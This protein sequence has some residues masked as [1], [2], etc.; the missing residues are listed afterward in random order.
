MLAPVRAVAVIAVAVLGAGPAP[1]SPA[2]A[3]PA[4]PVAPVAP[5]ATH[6]RVST[7]VQPTV[8]L[9]GRGATVSGGVRPRAPGAAVKLQVLVDS[10]WRTVAVATLG[11]RSGYVVTYTP[12]AV[13]TYQLRV[14]KPADSGHRR[15]TSR[16]VTLKATPSLPPT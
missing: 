4:A 9:V 3:A 5:V 14:R 12:A 2:A 15:G 6:Y 13:G 7:D 10:R 11:S 8:V 1:P 16:M